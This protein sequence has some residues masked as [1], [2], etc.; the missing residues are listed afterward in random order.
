VVAHVVVCL[1]GLSSGIVTK[2]VKS[3]WLQGLVLILRT[4]GSK[5]CAFLYVL[6]NQTKVKAFKKTSAA[7]RVCSNLWKHL[8]FFNSDLTMVYLTNT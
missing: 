2:S 1:E 4:G 7:L 6:S 8:S 3:P 5:T